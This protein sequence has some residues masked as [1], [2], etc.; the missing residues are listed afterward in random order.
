MTDLDRTV[1]FLQRLMR[2]PGLPGEEGATAEIVRDE[3]KALG[4]DE[5]SVDECGSVVGLVRGEARRPSLMFN[6]H[7]DHVDVGDPARWP[8]PPF[9]AEIAEGRVWG[10]GAVDIKGPLAAQVHGVARLLAEGERPPFDVYVSAVVQEEIGG[11]GARHLAERLATDL[12]VIGEPSSNELRRGHR[13][14]TEL[15]VHLTGRSV[16]AS[17]PER[18]VNPLYVL[19]AFLERL[20]SVELP[21]DPELGPT[22]VAPTLIRTDQV[23]RNVVPGEV[24][25][26]LDVRAGPATTPDVL[27]S[28]LGPA[29]EEAAAAVPGAAA[30]ILVPAAEHRTWTGLAREVPAVNPSWVRAADD[31]AVTTAGDVLE[32]ALGARPPVGLWKFATDGGHFVAHGSTVIGIGPGDETLAHTVRES[33]ELSELERALAINEALARA[34]PAAWRVAKGGGAA[35]AT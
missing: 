23:S 6:T 25:L 13:G 5:V 17:A 34:W 26:T 8:H 20:P 1:D 27:R 2:T 32:G 3:M 33:L 30:E 7:L 16:H 12:V 22:S 4:Y 19:A 28:L 18:G 35:G 24:W 11:L 10:R 14:R 31:P 9:G 29:L 15:G 21:E